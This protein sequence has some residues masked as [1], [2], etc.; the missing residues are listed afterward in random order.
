MLKNILYILFIFVCVNV[1]AAILFEAGIQGIP[2]TPYNIEDLSEEWN[3]TEIVES[4]EWTDPSNIGDV[5]SGLRF[6]WNKNIPVIES[7]TE[8]L[9]LYGAPDF[10]VNG[11]KVPY[12]F[13]MMLFVIGFIS[14]RW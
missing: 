14:G 12:R 5:V 1:A 13:L 3:G 11:V 10:I 4:W 6:F 8:M 7:F 9:Q 2:Q